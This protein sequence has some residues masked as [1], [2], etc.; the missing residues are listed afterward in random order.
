MPSD[1]S[2]ERKPGR[3]R[4]AAEGA[5]LRLE[6]E[7]WDND[8]GHVKATGW[9]VIRSAAEE[10]PYTVILTPGVGGPSEQHFATMLEAEAFIKQRTC[11]QG[12]TLS[13]RYDDYFGAPGDR[14]DRV[15]EA[16][17]AA[18][19][20]NIL[21]RLRTIEQRLRRISSEDAASVLADGLASAGLHEN[22][23]L[24]LIE[25]IERILDERDR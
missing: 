3:L 19:N 22:D 13:S 2:L 4:S 7:I 12:P 21:T 18:A 25:E 14:R 6:E 11:L 24:L 10:L 9:R 23:R 15:A 16:D 1:T 17:I 20:E 5:A 8:G